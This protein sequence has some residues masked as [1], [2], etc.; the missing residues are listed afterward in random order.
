MNQ[1]EAYQTDPKRAFPQ[2][3]QTIEDHK[4]NMRNIRLGYRLRKEEDPNA[5]QT[6]ECVLW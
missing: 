2:L 4:E 5:Y 3:L 6:Y 1:T